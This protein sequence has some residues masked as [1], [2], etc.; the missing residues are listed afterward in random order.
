MTEAELL[1]CTDPHKTVGVP[2]G[3]GQRPKIAAVCLCLLP[4]AMAQLG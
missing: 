3:Q 4:P 1:E 2:A